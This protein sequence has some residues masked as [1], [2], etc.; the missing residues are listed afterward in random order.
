MLTPF[1]QKMYL[2]YYSMCGSIETTLKSRGGWGMVDQVSALRKAVR[3]LNRDMQQIIQDIEVMRYTLYTL[4]V[5]IV[6]IIYWQV[7][8]YYS[9]RLE[10]PVDEVNGE[11]GEYD[12]NGSEGGP[13]K[14]EQLGI[15]SDAATVEVG[16]VILGRSYG[17]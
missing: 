5:V 13:R 3:K 12:E 7:L 8:R 14:S 6:L 15:R 16:C 9:E 11:D 10:N 17:V 1:D 4:W 2:I